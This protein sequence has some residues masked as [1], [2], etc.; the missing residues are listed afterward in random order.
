MPFFSIGLV[1]VYTYTHRMT[2]GASFPARNRFRFV[3]SFKNFSILEES[4]SKVAVG[5]GRFYKNIETFP[6]GGFDSF[7]CSTLSLTLP[8]DIETLDIFALPQSMA[9]KRNL[10]LLLEKIM[11]GMLVFF[12]LNIKC[13]WQE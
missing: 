1:G 6:R 10:V 13:P 4:V 11:C 3:Y 2:L 8:R 7:T 9:D 12:F 5:N